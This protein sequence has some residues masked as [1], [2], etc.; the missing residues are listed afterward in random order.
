MM[1]T[2]TLAPTLPNSVLDETFRILSSTS[3]TSQYRLV[4]KQW[5][6]IRPIEL[7]MMDKYKCA[8][9]SFRKAVQGGNRD[10]CVYFLDKIDNS[11][12]SPEVYLYI[13][14]RNNSVDICDIIMKHKWNYTMKYKCIIFDE[15]NEM[16]EVDC[17]S[18]YDIK[19]YLHEAF[20]IAVKQC[21]YDVC[22]YF[23]DNYKNDIHVNEA[24]CLFSELMISAK[25]G[26]FDICCLILEN[27]KYSIHALSWALIFAAESGFLDLCKV[28]Y[29]HGGRPNYSYSRSLH[30]ASK[31]GHYDVCLFLSTTPEYSAS[32]C[33]DQ[34][35]SLRIAAEKG[36]YNICDLLTNKQKF[37]RSVAKP[38]MLSHQALL[39]AVKGSFYDIVRLLV[40]RGADPSTQKS[41]CLKIAASRNDIEMCRILIELGA[42]PLNIEL[43]NNDIYELLANEKKKRRV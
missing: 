42:N 15:N 19:T 29:N 39:K 27:Y 5:K 26:Y 9:T 41:I 2:P 36:Y 11:K 14:I 21:V 35:A 8:S 30:H 17:E 7:L 40:S 43:Y 10:L 16:K 33:H 32:P 20:H 3:T 18:I 12:Y 31:N 34:S 38:R 28:I 1:P 22:K 24:D 23:I 25:R 37:G 4:C 6:S 13:A